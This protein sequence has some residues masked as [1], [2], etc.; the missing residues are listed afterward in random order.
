MTPAPR[1][2]PE[3]SSPPPVSYLGAYAGHGGTINAGNVI[4]YQHNESVPRKRTAQGS[5]R[6]GDS[7]AVAILTVLAEES[8]AV[9]EVL[10]RHRGYRSEQFY[11]G[12]QVHRARVDAEGGELRV[13]A[14]QT[15]DRGPLS[16][17][18]AYGRLRD[19]FGPPVVLLVGIAGGIGVGVDIGDVVIAD[20][21][22][23]YDSRRETDDGPRRRGRSQS[24]APVLRHRVNEFFTRCGGSVQ[25]PP[26]GEIRI[27]RG[28]IGSGDAVITDADSDIISYLRSFNEKTL[29]VETE[30]S[31]VGQ[32]FY[33][34]IEHE[35]SL[36]GW[37]TIRGIS[38]LADRRKG[39]RW[40]GFAAQRAAVVMDRLLPLLNLADPPQ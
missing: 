29:A 9:V 40:Q 16:A 25:V 27:R 14:M 12:P 38:D 7:A 24:V 4:G 2:G 6:Q 30:A 13:V 10:R 3:G 17:A 26:D 1:H 35:A 18:M 36:E 8:D 5:T 21:V 32:A 15:L 31:G 19:S 20:E 37:L 22:I 28:P 33:E 34:R 39:Q 11:G 23:H